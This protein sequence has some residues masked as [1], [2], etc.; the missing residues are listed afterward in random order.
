MTKALALL[1]ATA[2][3]LGITAAAN[4]QE[5]VQ[6]NIPFDFIVGGKTLPAGTYTVS[7]LADEKPELRVI[8]GSEG[9]G[10][11]AFVV[12]SASPA[13]GSSLLFHRYGT[14]YFL[15]DLVTASG[16]Y[17]LP[18]TPTERTAAQKTQHEDAV[19]GGGS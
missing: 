3:L 14:R 1:F 8:R 16:E 18:R 19:V 12:G 15:S 13:A 5:Q 6:V 2:L 4:A 7:R 9:Q 17:H 10:A 11:L